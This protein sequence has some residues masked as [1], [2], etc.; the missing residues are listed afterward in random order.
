MPHGF[1]SAAFSVCPHG[2]AHFASIRAS[3]SAPGSSYGISSHLYWRLTVIYR[4]M[5]RSLH[6]LMSATIFMVVQKRTLCW[7]NTEVS[8]RNAVLATATASGAQLL[9]VASA[10]AEMSDGGLASRLTKRDPALLKNSIF[11]LPPSAQIYPDFM[12]GNWKVSCQ[13]NGYLFPSLQIPKERLLQNAD[14]PGFQKCSIAAICDVGKVVIEYE[15]RIDPSTGLEDRIATLTSTING[16][17]GYPAVAEVIYNASKNPNRISIDFVEYKTRNA[18]RIEL[19]CNARESETY[20]PQDDSQVFVSSEYVRQ[21]TFS[22]SADVG[23]ARQV[24]GNYAHFWTWKQRREE[25]ETIT[26][27][28]L[29]ASYLDPQDSLF[30]DEPSK[31][32]AIYS[33][34]LTANRI[35]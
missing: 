31:P 9:D 25:T 35:I 32:V 11:N 20:S 2:R 23:I 17:L 15:M 4:T 21:V 19:F 10:K 8:R 18:E 30:F 33:H 22:G 7:S 5:I 12:R 3:L 14:I 24:V 34:I 28:L 29:T 26:G 27:N 6:L 16:C 1:S 13:F